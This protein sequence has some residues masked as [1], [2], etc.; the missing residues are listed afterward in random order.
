V[1][2]LLLLASGSPLAGQDYF[3]RHNFTFG[4][5]VARPRGDLGAAL[6][7]APGISIAYGYRFQRYLQADI[8]FDSIF[9]AAQVRDFLDTGLGP[10]RISDREYF[11][12][13]GG[14]V[15][16]PLGRGRVL[17]SGG[18]GGVWMKYHERVQQP[19]ENLHIQCPSCTSRS[20]WGYYALGNASFF[21]D[22][23][24]HFRV[25]ATAR[26]VRGNTDGDAI[27]FVPGFQ[28]KDHWLTLGGEFG[29][30]F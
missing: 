15:I 29:F 5:G 10:L 4:M 25:G 6:E 14:R 19:G 30:S 18:G 22:S 12:P 28:T 1:G 2:L 7:D 17:I 16:A 9:G 20:G 11:V 8:G 21:I 23:G 27:G 3:P 26:V 24:R 13:F